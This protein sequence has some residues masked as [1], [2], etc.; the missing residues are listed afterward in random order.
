M[1]KRLHCRPSPD[2]VGGFIHASRLTSLCTFVLGSL[3]FADYQSNSVV[4]QVR[5]FKTDVQMNK[6]DSAESVIEGLEAQVR[7]VVAPSRAY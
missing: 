1:F 2:Q 5:G 4:V 3:G 6:P 7:D